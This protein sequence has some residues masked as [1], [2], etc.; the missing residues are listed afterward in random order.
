VGAFVE[1]LAGILP[2]GFVFGGAAVRTG[3]DGFEHGT[4]NWFHLVCLIR[5]RCKK[6][7]AASCSVLMLNY[8]RLAQRFTQYLLFDATARTASGELAVDDN[9]RHALYAVLRGAISNRSLVHVVHDD[10][11]LRACQLLHVCDSVMAGFAT[12]AE[13]L[14]FV[15]HVLVLLLSS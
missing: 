6:A 10:F 11:M 13:N 4:I 8:V 14:N 9:R 7:A 12:G 3:Q 15:F 5:K 2:H 1:E